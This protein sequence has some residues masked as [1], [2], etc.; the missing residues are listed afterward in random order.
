M[1]LRSRALFQPPLSHEV[2]AAPAAS[3]PVEAGLTRT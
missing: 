1:A 3:L 2:G